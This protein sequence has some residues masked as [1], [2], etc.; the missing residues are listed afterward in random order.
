MLRCDSG[1]AEVA[2]TCDALIR[3]QNVRLWSSE[4]AVGRLPPITYSFDVSVDD[5]VFV[6][7]GEYEDKIRSA[8]I[9]SAS[10]R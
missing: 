9:Y 10:S 8:T 7:C 4:R 6:H 2:Q 5:V 1:E 3:D